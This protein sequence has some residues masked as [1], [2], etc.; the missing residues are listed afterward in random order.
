MINDVDET[1]KQLLVQKVPLDAAEV[2]IRS[3]IPASHR[4]RSGCANVDT[5]WTGRQP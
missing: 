3:D 4:Q 1:L 2:D 5:Q